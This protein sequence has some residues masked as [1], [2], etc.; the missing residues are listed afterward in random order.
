MAKTEDIDSLPTAVLHF[1]RQNPRLA[2]YGI[3]G[4]AKE[5][6]VISI[7]WDAMD[8]KELVQSIAASGYFEHEPLIVAEEDN[9]KV[10]IEGNRRLAAVKALLDP[11]LATEKGWDVPTLKKADLKKLENLPVKISTREELWRYIGFKHVNGPAKWSSYAKAKYI[12]DIH[13]KYRISLED[14]AGQIGDRHKTVQRLYRGLMVIEQAERK[15]VYDR[16]NRF[17]KRFAFSHLYTGLDYDGIS[18]FLSLKS[19]D[20]ETRTPVPN[21]AISRLGE[22]CVWLYG[23]KKESKPPVVETQNPHLRQLNEILKSREALA[24]LRDGKELAVALELSRLPTDV[25][26]EALLKSK[27]ELQNARAY[28]TTGYDGSEDL[29]HIAETVVEMAEDVYSEMLRKRN[30]KRHPSRNRARVA[31]E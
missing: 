9:K 15:E 30:R 23:D 20:A 1:D 28:M 2:E 11:N 21:K 16:D 31:E 6:D 26:E 12:A 14:I 4:T 8:I 27:R 17:R 7:L 10:V 13:R 29:L 3:P 19:V 24:A 22:L 5:D 25:F 18:K